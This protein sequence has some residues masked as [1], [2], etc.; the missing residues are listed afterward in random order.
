MDLERGSSSG[1]AP[2]NGS[3]D[4]RVLVRPDDCAVTSRAFTRSIQVG[5]GPEDL[6][7]KDLGAVGAISS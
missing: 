2:A 5:A 4:S 7:G 1:H 3:M 6:P